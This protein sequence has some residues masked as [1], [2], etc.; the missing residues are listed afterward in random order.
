MKLTASD[1]NLVFIDLE[2]ARECMRRRR[3]RRRM[4]Q[5]VT[6][7]WRTLSSVQNLTNEPTFR[8]AFLFVLY[9]IVLDR[10]K[11]AEMT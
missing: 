6:N 1:E 3:K 4:G 7:R 2:I 5:R 8:K 9:P 11:L 10:I